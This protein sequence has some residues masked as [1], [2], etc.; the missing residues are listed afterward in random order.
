MMK[1]KN[2]VS[3]HH[4]V[5]RLT[6]VCLYWDLYQ[7]LNRFYMSYKSPTDDLLSLLELLYLCNVPHC[8]WANNACINIQPVQAHCAE[9]DQITCTNIYLIITDSS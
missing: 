3:F 6:S 8:T 5:T 2:N 7:S 9:T 4:F 1:L